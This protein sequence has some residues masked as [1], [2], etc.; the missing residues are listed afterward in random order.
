MGGRAV[1][2]L[3]AAIGL[4]AAVSSTAI[5]ALAGVLGNRSWRDGLVGAV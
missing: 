4:A 1:R 2:V 3:V 5:P